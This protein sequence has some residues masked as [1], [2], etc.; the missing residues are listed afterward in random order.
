MQISNWQSVEIPGVEVFVG[1]SAASWVAVADGN[2]VG[3]GMTV[4]N[5]VLVEIEMDVLLT[6][7][8]A[9]RKRITNKL[10]NKHHAE[11][12]RRNFLRLILHDLEVCGEK[13]KL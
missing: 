11:E 5:G 9:V 7:W 10:T 1:T 12:S 13:I 4:L 2:K 6:G 3:K 8:Q